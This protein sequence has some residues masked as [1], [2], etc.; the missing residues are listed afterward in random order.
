MKSEHQK[1]F[2]DNFALHCLLPINTFVCYFRENG[3]NDNTNDDNDDDDDDDNDHHHHHHHHNGTEFYL[4]V[5]V[6]CLFCGRLDDGHT[7]H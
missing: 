6:A 2:F 7:F 1:D 4:A 5:T 3:F